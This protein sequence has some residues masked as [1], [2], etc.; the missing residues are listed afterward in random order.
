MEALVL[1]LFALFDRHLSV[2]RLVMSFLLLHG[3]ICM[4]TRH[5]SIKNIAIRK[6]L[7][8]VT[9]REVRQHMTYIHKLKEEVLF[10]GR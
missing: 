4:G 10:T 8:T 7:K 9:T 3:K 6:W 5:L 2:E 1:K